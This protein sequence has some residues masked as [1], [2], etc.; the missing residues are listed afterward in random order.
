MWWIARHLYFGKKGK[1]CR[2]CIITTYFFE[3]VFSCACLVAGGTR[4]RP[5]SAI[6]S[7]E[8]HTSFTLPSSRR[9]TTI[10]GFHGNNLS[11]SLS[12]SN[13]AGWAAT[14]VFVF[15]FVCTC[16][17][18]TYKY[19]LIL[20]KCSCCHY[21]WLKPVISV[22]IQF[23]VSVYL[24]QPLLLYVMTTVFMLSHFY[25]F[26]VCSVR[27]LTRCLLKAC[28][29]SPSQRTPSTEP[30]RSRNPWNHSLMKVNDTHT[31]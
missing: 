9:P 3:K 26:S 27:C 30:T 14:A 20:I 10:M 19:I 25:L 28:G 13:I 1:L 22:N 4:E 18:Q 11:K 16:L 15:V 23:C 17:T 2:F 29:I 12:I 21:S 6:L 24:N 8:D 5:W 31:L 7:P